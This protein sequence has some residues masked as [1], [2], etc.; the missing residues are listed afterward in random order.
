MSG[1]REQRKG[2]SVAHGGDGGGDEG[3][4]RNPQQEALAHRI[5]QAIVYNREHPDQVEDFDRLTG[6]VAA[7]G[8]RAIMAWQRAHDLKGD[9]KVGPGTLNAAATASQAK[10]E[11]EEGAEQAQ[12]GGEGAGGS[13]AGADGMQ[14]TPGALPP[15]AAQ[16]GGGGAAKHGG[17]AKPDGKKAERIEF[18]D[19]EAGAVT[20]GDAFEGEGVDDA[21]PVMKNPVPLAERMVEHGATPGQEHRTKDGKKEADEDHERLGS[22]V[23]EAIE[24]SAEGVDAIEEAGAKG[25]AAV[26]GVAFIA[27]VPHLCDLIRDHQYGEAIK[28]AI[29]SVGWEDR[30]EIMKYA[31]ERMAGEIG[32]KLAAALEGA[33]IAGMVTDVLFLGWE[34]TKA[35]FEAI[36]EAHEKGDQDS[37]I[38]IYAFAWADVVVNGHHSNPGA[39]TAEQREAMEL[40]IR[41]GLTTR[42]SNPGLAELLLAEY[43][44]KSNARHAL[45][46]AVFKEGG[47]KVVTHHE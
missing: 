42:A 20:G 4:Q 12:A 36:R 11:G 22:T 6:G 13:T 25:T 46:D 34:W 40:G 7:K 31:I 5:K 29:D 45:Q 18:S 39:V 19:E 23:P 15:G 41:D 10:P 2:G 38:A 37:R 44:D 16:H 28:Y 30:A 33:A 21:G 14:A 17:G 27:K 8:I 47:N 26:K 24:K 3:A 43:H 32:P 9:G 35:G 1:G